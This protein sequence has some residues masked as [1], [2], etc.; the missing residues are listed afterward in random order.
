MKAPLPGGYYRPQ[1]VEEPQDTPHKIRPLFGDA[2]R[3][4]NE[5][6]IRYQCHIPIYTASY[7]FV[8]NICYSIII[9][10]SYTVLVL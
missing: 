3:A 8:M 10:T 2:M 6:T 1:R 7:M 4:D 9:P 5:Y